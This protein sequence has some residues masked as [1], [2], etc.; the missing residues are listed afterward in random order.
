VEV[1][2]VIET[3]EEMTAPGEVLFVVDGK[4]LRLTPFVEQGSRE[5]FFVF[6]DRT[7]GHETYGGG[8]FLD[9]PA[10]TG[11]RVVLDFN[12]AYNPPCAFTPY[13]TCPVPRREN[14][15]PIRVTAGE[16]AYGE[17]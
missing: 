11:E 10:P 7:N 1:S 3:T 9:A 14:R 15:L 12:R 4:E 17:H 8:R 2:T 16:K 5:L 13:A 6:G